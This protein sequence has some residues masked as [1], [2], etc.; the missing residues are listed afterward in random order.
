[1][2]KVGFE[3]N[4]LQTTVS[5]LKNETSE[6]NDTNIGYIMGTTMGTTVNVNAN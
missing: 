2:E 1:L 4:A 5:I 3:I 6:R